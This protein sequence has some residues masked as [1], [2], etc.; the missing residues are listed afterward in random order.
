MALNRSSVRRLSLDGP[1]RVAHTH[2]DQEWVPHWHDEWSFGATIGGGCHCS[3][4]GQP[5]HTRRGDVML[6][7]PGTVHTGAVRDSAE[8]GPAH[9]VMLHASAS[10]LAARALA[11]GHQVVLMHAPALAS[12]AA[13]IDSG[14]RAEAWIRQ[15]LGQA[16]AEQ[17]RAWP[18][19]TASTNQRLL[20]EVQMAIQE[21]VCNVAAL[22]VRC[23]V[24]RKWMHLQLTRW[25][26]L[27]PSDYLRTARLHRARALIDAG[28]SPADAA[29]ACGFADQA[30]FTRWFRRAFGYTPG[31]WAAAARDADRAGRAPA[32]LIPG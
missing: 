23:G 21:G 2:G 24:S 28:A 10:W 15:V 8:L 16:Q 20:G 13:E 29:A 14:E 30:H 18:V 1:A 3:V 31:D 4:A 25:T 27:S 17:A 19:P 12:A 32:A 6:I 11:P 7:P 9:V 26:G 22:A 5:L